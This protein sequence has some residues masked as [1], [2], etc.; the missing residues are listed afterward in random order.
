MARRYGA[1]CALVLAAACGGRAEWFDGSMKDALAEA[2]ARGTVLVVSVSAAWC[3][4]CHELERLFWNTRHGR[5]AGERYVL[6]LVD[7]D[8]DEGQRL[9]MRH[10]I[11]S[12]P[13]TLVLDPK[14]HEVGRVVGFEGVRDFSRRLADTAGGRA[15]TVADLERRHEADPGDLDTAVAL[16]EAQL[17]AGLQSQG[18]DV[19]E[20]VIEK[21][22]D[23][24]AGAYMDATRV[25]GRYFVRCKKDY[26]YGTAY[27]Q[28]AVDAFPD[29]PESWEFRS[30][31]G[32][33]LWE[34]GKTDE[35]RAYFEKLA[36]DHASK[37]AAHSIRARFLERQCVDLETALSEI[38]KAIEIDP[39]DDWSCYVEAEVLHKLGRKQEALESLDRAIDLAAEDQCL[40]LDR[41]EEWSV[42]APPGGAGR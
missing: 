40:Y 30:W 31:I 38:R 21:D 24:K 33:A 6:K 3:P 1:A 41:K 23:N 29:A 9:V 36:A 17:Q 11:I 16:G 25:L 5:K 32:Q 2:Q 13:T 42:E 14:G 37:A 8:G 35:A 39:S 10:S 4:S 20:A 12:I 26:Y 19:L 34:S 27:F 28:K 18:V 15:P 7:F 22:R